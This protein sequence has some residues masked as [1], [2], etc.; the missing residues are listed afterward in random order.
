MYAD[1]TTMFK[2]HK[3]LRLLRLPEAKIHLQNSF[4]RYN[5]PLLHEEYPHLYEDAGNE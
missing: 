2:L 1:S 5:F 3:Y 4:I